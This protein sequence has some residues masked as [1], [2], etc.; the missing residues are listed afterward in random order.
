MAISAGKEIKSGTARISLLA[1][2]GGWKAGKNA[3]QGIRWDGGKL[4]VPKSALRVEALAWATKSYSTLGAAWRAQE[5]DAT[6]KKTVDMSFS[7]WNAEFLS[8]DSSHAKPRSGRLAGGL[9]FN[10]LIDFDQGSTCIFNSWSFSDGTTEIVEYGG[11]LY[12]NWDATN[13]S[14][15]NIGTL[16]ATGEVS[17]NDPAVKFQSLKV[18]D[19]PARNL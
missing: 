5:K 7:D 18:T 13:G 12:K 9:T 10:V 8:A 1:V 15:E 11:T 2:K 14:G 4:I 17:I 16:S 3:V 19:D 6:A